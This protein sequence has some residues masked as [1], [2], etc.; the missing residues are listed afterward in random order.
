MKYVYILLVFGLISCNNSSHKPEEKIVNAEPLMGTWQYLDKYGNYNEVYFGKDAYQTFNRFVDRK[1][2]FPYK[3]MND[4]LY[5]TADRKRAGMSAVAAI[6]WISNESVILYTSLFRD[7][8]YRLEGAKKT[9]AD[10]DPFSDSL[11]FY[12]AFFERYEKFLIQRG[13]ITET[14]VMQFREEGKVPEDV[15]KPRN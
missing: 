3:V 2:T 1:I 6:E 4:S 10:T 7:T 13:I 11:Q 8:L 15:D 9:L 12:P 5:S 14:E